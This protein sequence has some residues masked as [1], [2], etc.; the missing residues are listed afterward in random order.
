MHPLCSLCLFRPGGTMV[1]YGGMAK[2]PVIASVVSRWGRPARGPGL[3]SC[4]HSGSARPW[5]KDVYFKWCLKPSSSEPQ[6]VLLCPQSLLIF[7]DLKLRGFWL[8]QWK[9][10]HSPGECMVAP[11]PGVTQEGS[12][13]CVTRSPG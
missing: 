9:K 8:S 1:T 6:C 13:C 3:H 2:Q 5:G 7:K 11:S 10:D 12:A 4:L